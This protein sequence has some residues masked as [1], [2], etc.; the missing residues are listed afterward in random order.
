MGTNHQKTENFQFPS[1]FKA[2]RQKMKVAILCLVL[3]LFVAIEAAAI[4]AENDGRRFADEET[5]MKES[6][7]AVAYA[8]MVVRKLRPC[9]DCCYDGK[10]DGE[11]SLLRYLRRIVLILQIVHS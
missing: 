8:R 11:S 7:P 3:A 5:Y 4:E 9:A 1:P 10:R 2:K 6:E